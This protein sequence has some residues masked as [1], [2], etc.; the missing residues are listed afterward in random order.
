[1]GK[2]HAGIVKS[3][4]L[5]ITIHLKNNLVYQLISGFLPSLLL[6]VL[7]CVSLFFPVTDFNERIMG[8]L[9]SLLVL[10]TIVATASSVN[11]QTQYLKFID[12]WYILMT[13]YCFLIVVVNAF[14]NSLILV[15]RDSVIPIE[16]I[17]AAMKKA[18]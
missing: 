5:V 10:A 13:V 6:S 7:S 12:I 3:S 8:S 15:Q 2:T 18:E 17:K 4:Y 14:I 9:T 1:L 11:V 16:T